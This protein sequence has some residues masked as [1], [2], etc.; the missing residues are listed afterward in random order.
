MNHYLLNPAATGITDRLPISL[1][2]RKIWAGMNNTP[3][4][5]Y[6]SGNMLV[7]EDMGV[8]ARIS[9]FQAGPLRKTGIEG[10]Y[11]YHLSLGSGDTRLS[12]GL[13]VLLYQFNLNKSDMIVEDIDDEVFM[14]KEQQFVPD[15]GFGAYLYGNNY[16]VGLSVPQLFQRNI[17]LKSDIVFQQKQVRHY[18]LHGGYTFDAGSD[19]KIVPSALIKFMETGLFQV[20]INALVTYKE[21]INF[22]VSYRSEEAMSFQVGYM[23]PDIFIGYAY[24]LVLSGMRGNTSGSHEILFTYTLDNFLVK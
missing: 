12:F 2:Y 11:S 19:F 5:Q 1:S 16:F 8:G 3:S 22:G 23:N 15:A 9:N 24:D 20:D 6:L 14:G 21:M 18:Y 10:S 13:S 4:V 7:T 17:D